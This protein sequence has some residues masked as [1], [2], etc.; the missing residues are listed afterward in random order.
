MVTAAQPQFNEVNLDCCPPAT[1]GNFNIFYTDANGVDQHFHGTD[2]LFAGHAGT[3]SPL[4]PTRCFGPGLTAPGGGPDSCFSEIEGWFQGD[5]IGK[6]G[7]FFA[8]FDLR[9][10]DEANATTDSVVTVRI[11]DSAGTLL[12]SAEQVSVAKG[13]GNLQAHGGC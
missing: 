1:G 13:D 9:D 12:A 6:T 3:S 2:Q 4:A 8:Y 10:V 5:I 7:T 11:Y